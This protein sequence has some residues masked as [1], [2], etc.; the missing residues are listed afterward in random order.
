MKDCPCGLD[1]PYTDCCGRLIR[2][3]G[4]ADAAE[5]LMRSRYTA[6][7][8]KEWDYLVNTLCADERSKKTA[9]EFEKGSRHLQWQ[10]LEI[11]GTRQGGPE[12]NEGQVEFAAHY[13]EN[14]DAKS[15]HETA[16]FLKE[17]GRWG[18]SEK[19]SKSHVHAAG[20]PCGH[21]H[22]PQKPV[23]REGAK[24]GR[25]DPCPCGSGKKFKK[26]CGK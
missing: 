20:E 1:S 11:H 14:G 23:V 18:Y 17:K 8:L 4:Y 21:S 9:A 15:L 26:C 5:D 16:H 24:V 25:N 19:L 7:V 3:A 12:D 6:F 2:G 22:E 13:T 10:K